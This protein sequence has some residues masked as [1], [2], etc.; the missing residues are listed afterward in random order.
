M[1]GPFT[2]PRLEQTYN[3]VLASDLL[4][5][6]YNHIPEG[7]KTAPV[8]Q[9]LRSWEGDNPFYE[10]R[11]LRAPRGS[12]GLLPMHKPI[13]FRNIPKLERITVHSMAK[14][15][16]ASKDS[17]W[18][19]VAGMAV[20]A[21]TGKRVETHA[22]KISVQGWN[23]RPGRYIS[24]TAEMRGEDMYHFLSK[25]VEMVLPRMKDWHGVAGTS[26]DSTGN[27]SFGLKPHELSLFPEIEVN[28]DM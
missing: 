23:L 15:A 25:L 3:D 27:I 1:P 4:T 12:T 9:R 13:N 28:Y 5:M 11:P 7:G 18:L 6:C 24:V 22:S 16:S 10:N 8:E 2:L 21:I 19:H 17:S 26:G 14:E 20:Q